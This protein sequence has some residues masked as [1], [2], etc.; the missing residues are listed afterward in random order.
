[1]VDSE[2]SR[3]GLYIVV[4]C[5][6]VATDI[7]AMLNSLLSQRFQHFE[8]L[9]YD[10]A[11][12][13][14]TLSV[15]QNTVGED[16][17]FRVISGTIQVWAAVGRW[18]CLQQIHQAAKN[19]IVVLLDGDDWLYS[20]DVLEFLMNEYFHSPYLSGHG[21]F[22]SST[23]EHCDWSKDYPEEIKVQ[24]K[25]RD[26]AWI[27][28]H[29]RWFRLGLMEYIPYSVLLDANGDPFKI[30]TDFA[31]FL[32]ILELSGVYTVYTAKT[33]YVYN[34]RNGGVDDPERRKAQRQAELEIRKKKALKPVNAGTI[35]GYLK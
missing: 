14:H 25:Y 21:N 31:L 32:P 2:F 26:Y 13:D 17:R 20:D 4:S 9:I 28:T 7:P 23:G 6:N 8:C 30:S 33:L 22:M 10:D 34:R 15:I 5:R 1:M 19:S 35:S 3:P 11:S 16:K 18:L 24:A 12:S 27:A 29:L